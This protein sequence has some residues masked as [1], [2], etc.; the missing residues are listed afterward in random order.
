M[1]LKV[2]CTHQTEARSNSH[3][4]SLLPAIHANTTTTS[5]ESIVHRPALPSKVWGKEGLSNLTSQ[6]LKALIREAVITIL[7]CQ[8]TPNRHPSL[9]LNN[10]F[11]K[12]NLISSKTPFL[13]GANSTHTTNSLSSLFNPSSSRGGKSQGTRTRF[14]IHRCAVHCTPRTAKRV[15][16]RTTA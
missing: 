6:T 16:R 4:V 3:M 10:P 9:C 11:F 5:W 12:A 2:V 15:S 1:D 13:P 14:C 8:G 7:M